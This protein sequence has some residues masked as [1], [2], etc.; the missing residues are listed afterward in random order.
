MKII[1]TGYDGDDADGVFILSDDET[2]AFSDMIVK[3]VV[4]LPSFMYNLKYNL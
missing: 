3:M 2:T 4:S 1:T